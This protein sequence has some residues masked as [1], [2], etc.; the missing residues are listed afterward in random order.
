MK[1]TKM[2]CVAVMT[3]FAV[4]TIP[5]WINAQEQAREQDVKHHHY[6]LIDVGTFGGPASAF[7]SGRML[8]KR[9]VAVGASETSVPDQLSSNG[10]PCGPGAFVYHAFDFQNDHVIDLGS[11]PGTDRFCSNANSINA[12][13]EIVGN[14]EIRKI[15]SVLGLHEIR[16]VRWNGNL[17][18]NLGTLGGKH[19]A[20]NDINDRDQIVGFALNEIPDPWSMFYL[21]FGNPNGTQ[22]RAFLWQRGTMQ[23]LGTLGGPDAMAS[24]I[25]RQGQVTGISFTNSIPND[26]TGFPTQDPFLW[27]KGQIIDIGSLGG[28]FGQPSALNNRG[29]VAG[30]SNLTGDETQHAFLWDRGTLTDLGTLGG[31]FSLANWLNDEGEVVGAATTPGDS[32]LHATLWRKGKITDLGT[33][34]DDCFSLAN[35]INAKDQI[36]GQSFSCDGT[37]AREVL[38]D[39]GVTIDL[40]ARILPGSN[41]AA[42]NPMAINE[43]GEIVGKGVPPGCDS[44]D[45]CG[46]SFVLL[47]VDD[48]IEATTGAIRSDPAANPK[49]PAMPAQ[50]RLMTQEFVAQLRA[51]LAQQNHLP[52]ARAGRR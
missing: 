47:P 31:T 39:K 10:W 51:R 34:P 48:D 6:Q 23:D 52:N 11:L 46:H 3:A 33:L 42:I 26:T 29:Q 16:A 12:Q 22:T 43:R 8:N 9:G 41:L 36:V 49:S 21:A 1:S 45:Q 24:F 7:N 37:I 14:S 19:S 5:T 44:E 38:W 27:E 32:L 25:N 28:T 50:H 17:I 20:A 15:D 30:N 35:W 40:G 4:L 18:K 13:G 2:A